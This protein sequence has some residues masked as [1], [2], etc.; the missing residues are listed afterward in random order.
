MLTSNPLPSIVHAPPFSAHP[1]TNARA[2]GTQ[3]ATGISSN[4]AF[5]P[6]LDP[7]CGGR[8]MWFAPFD[9]RGLFGD[10]RHESL[11]VTDRSIGS[12]GS[13][14]IHIHPDIQMDFR[15]LPF[16]DATFQIVAFDPPHLVTAG[17]RSWMAAKY[18]RLGDDWRDDLKRGFAECF[19]VLKP[20]GVLIFKW[21][22][23]QIP[24]KDVLDC[25]DHT[26]L[27]GQRSGKASK[28]HWM[29][30]LK[31]DTPEPVNPLSIYTDGSCNTKTGSGGWAALIRRNDCRMEAEA[32]MGALA[33]LDGPQ[34]VAI[35]T[36][37]ELLVKGMTE[38]LPFWIQQRWKKSNKQKVKNRDVWERLMA[39][40]A[41]HQIT[42]HWMRGHAG[43]PDNARVHTL[44]RQAAK[45]GTVF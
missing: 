37:C 29:T 44:A 23:I 18:G 22:E 5:P 7:C 33:K 1:G 32:V 27:F 6:V 35:H 2:Q 9:Q 28:T 14:A 13:R 36:D 16:P 20:N 4:G 25:T 19:R 43:H 45:R 38:H 15:H 30:F 8:M 42:W 40:T 10:L 3:H 34:R 12:P 26:P 41:G 11:E 17:K 21:N 39:A 24:V 31:P